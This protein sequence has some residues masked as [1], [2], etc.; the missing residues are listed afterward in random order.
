MTEPASPQLLHGVVHRAALSRRTDDDWWGSALETALAAV[1]AAR[2][3]PAHRTEATGAV[4]R[5]TR[6]W[7]EGEARRISADIVAVALTAKAAAELVQRDDQLTADAAERVADLADRSTEI[8]PDQHVALCA[9]A[10]DG[11]VVDR[12]AKPWPQLRARVERGTA[13]GLDATLRA[14]TRAVAA[15]GFDAVTLVQA[16]LSTSPIVSPSTPDAASALWLLAVSVERVAQVLDADEPAL[17]ALLERRGQLVERLAVE[18]DERRSFDFAAV[19]DFDP[20]EEPDRS[21]TIVLSPMD[22]LLVDLALASPETSAPYLTPA[23][24]Q[25]LFGQREA[26]IRA[27]LDERERAAQLAISRWIARFGVLLSVL[28]AAL[29]ATLLLGLLLAGVAA[30]TAVWFALALAGAAVVAA[31]GLWRRAGE[32]TLALPLAVLAATFV[33]FGCVVGVNGATANP[34]LP[35][36]AGLVTGAIGTA[37][38]GFIVAVVFRLFDVASTAG[39]GSDD[40]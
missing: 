25:A 32:H 38:V 14:Y 30:S 33:L 4:A 23:E 28:G 27:L 24:A 9:W 6:W 22:T 37:A 15:P 8:V 31:A 40:A 34:F 29:G 20:D 12:T 17:R 39:S 36:A 16:L 19:G 35:D 3:P 5:L 13:F 1:S 7:R 18:V 2:H 21:P 26:H 11:L 10:L